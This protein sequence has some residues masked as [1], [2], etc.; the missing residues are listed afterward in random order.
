[1]EMFDNESN[2]ENMKVLTKIRDKMIQNNFAVYGEKIY[3]KIKKSKSSW[4]SCQNNEVL[5]DLLIDRETYC[6]YYDD[7]IEIIKDRYQTFFPKVEFDIRIIECADFFFDMINGEIVDKQKEFNC[8][9]YFPN[10]K[11][12]DLPKICNGELRPKK[13]LKIFEKS[14]VNREIY[15][16]L[17]SLFLPVVPGQKSFLII[18]QYHSR[19][20]ILLE[21]LRNFFPPDEI[22]F[23]HN[24]ERHF[25]PKCNN[26]NPEI[27]F[28]ET[29]CSELNQ[30]VLDNKFVWKQR[31]LVAIENELIR[32]YH[33]NGILK[34]MKINQ[35][36]L[37]HK[38][39]DEET[40]IL[41][42]RDKDESIYQ[43]Y[44]GINVDLID[45]N[46][47][48]NKMVGSVLLLYHIKSKTEEY[49]EEI[50]EEIGK[51][52]FFLAGQYFDSFKDVERFTTKKEEKIYLPKVE[53]SFIFPKIEDFAN[54]SIHLSSKSDREVISDYLHWHIQ[55]INKNDKTEPSFR[56]SFFHNIT[57]ILDQENELFTI[58]CKD[59]IVGYILSKNASMDIIEI[60]KPYRSEGIAR[61]AFRLWEEFQKGKDYVCCFASTVISPILVKLLP[62]MG[63]VEISTSKYGNPEPSFVKFFDIEPEKVEGDEHLISIE[64]FSRSRKKIGNIWKMKGFLKNGKYYLNPVY[65]DI[66]E[67]DGEIKIKIDGNEVYFGRIK[68]ATDGRDGDY[69]NKTII[70]GF[71]KIENTSDVFFAKRFSVKKNKLLL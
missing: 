26:K 52:L 13:W 57:M 69:Q 48:N 3:E 58:F 22:G 70:K 29:P 51:V 66:H 71:E 62:K 53:N 6:I 46:L 15:K 19:V 68:Y 41:T 2:G 17:Y 21:S 27:W 55:Y 9:L 33:P 1:M 50:I 59:V 24:A 38:N 10:I 42:I 61:K 64:K 44:Q 60:F 25:C 67:S 47:R 56:G 49:L 11:K 39:Y 65:I 31:T 34:S 7:F 30:K 8:F 28:I 36:D 16:D 45:K 35:E 4:K 14:N 5:I 32:D 43:Y 20:S 63:Y 37:D 54:I 23:S 18:H 40:K 12:T